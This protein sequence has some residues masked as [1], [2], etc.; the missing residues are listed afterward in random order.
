MSGSYYGEGSVNNYYYQASGAMLHQPV[1]P[2]EI[3]WTPV[4]KR[5]RLY[6]FGC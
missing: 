6:E 5:T 3:S 2:D 1:S 4:C